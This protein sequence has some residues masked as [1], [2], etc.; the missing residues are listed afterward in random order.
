MTLETS[1]LDGGAD[2]RA[3]QLFL[4]HER[5]NTTQLYT[6]VSIKRLKEVH[7]RTHPAK[8]DQRPEE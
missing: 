8:P 1:G 6:H 7:Q 4:G 3:L 5:L 2:V